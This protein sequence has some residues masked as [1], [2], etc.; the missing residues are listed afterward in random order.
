VFPLLGNAAAGLHVHDGTIAWDAVFVLGHGGEP[1]ADPML[2][3]QAIQDAHE[4]GRYWSL[5][6]APLTTGAFRPA[7]RRNFARACLV[8]AALGASPPILEAAAYSLETALVMNS[9]TAEE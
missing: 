7:D 4:R 5:R 3:A 1:I 2:T 6:L 9:S 8:A